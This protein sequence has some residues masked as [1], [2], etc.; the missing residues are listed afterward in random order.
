MDL[1]SKK[2]FQSES[3]PGVSFTLR[4][5]SASA[6]ARR[7]LS[8]SEHSLLRNE[9]ARK[10]YELYKPFKPAKGSTE[11]SPIPPDVMKEINV[12]TDHLGMLDEAYVKPA[13]IRAALLKIEGSTLDGKPYT[14]D[15]F[16]DYCT[17]DA[18]MEE[19]YERA[20]ELSGLP[21]EQASTFSSPSASDA[22]G[23]GSTSNTTATAA[24]PAEAGKTET[25][26]STTPST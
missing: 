17:D 12:L 3:S 21:P 24:I 20:K 6:R 23:A 9:I 19:V 26:S 14:A 1:E 10:G 2:T 15:S 13:T 11:E 18:L 7:D 25:A 8:I 22:A 5:L 16:I 4:R